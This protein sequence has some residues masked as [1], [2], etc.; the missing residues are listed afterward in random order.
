MTELGGWITVTTDANRKVGACGKV[1]PDMELAIVDDD[2][3]VLPAGTR[4][5]IVARPRRPHVIFDGYHGRPDITLAK[6]SNLWF[7]TGDLGEL[8][9][10]GFLTFHGR[11]D[12]MIRRAG[13]NVQP[14]DIEDIIAGMPGVREAVA[15][16]VPDEIMGQEIKLVVVVQPGVE[17]SAREVVDYAT[18]KLPRFAQPRYVE[19]LDKPLPRT[20]TQKIVRAAVRTFTRRSMTCSRP[21]HDGKAH[22]DGSPDV[23]TARF[24]A[25]RYALRTSAGVV[26]ERRARHWHHRPMIETHSVTT[27]YHPGIGGTAVAFYTPML[28]YRAIESAIREDALCHRRRFASVTVSSRRS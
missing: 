26:H 1:R 11:A 21:R 7:H 5:Q 28:T 12:E 8:D 6:M 22:H 25:L 3:N 23:C 24:T 27:D 13:E 18:A 15:V 19:I 16:G 2:D 10:D 14:T 20:S 4:G 17:L 9:D